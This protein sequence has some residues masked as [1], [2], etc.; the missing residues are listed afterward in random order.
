[1]PPTASFKH[2][3][4]PF[5]AVK[6]HGRTEQLSLT[7][8]MFTGTYLKKTAGIW[9]HR[10]ERRLQADGGKKTARSARLGTA[11]RST[12]ARLK[13]GAVLT[14]DCSQSVTVIAPRRVRSPCENKTIVMRMSAIGCESGGWRDNHTAAGATVFPALMYAC[15][16]PASVSLLLSLQVTAPRRWRRRLL[17]TRGCRCVCVCV[18]VQPTHL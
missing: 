6:H 15:W 1:M 8:Q 17:C 2:P 5:V 14:F 12:R 7:R 11:E 3:L 13:T 18:C 4:R 10:A 16:I 9:N